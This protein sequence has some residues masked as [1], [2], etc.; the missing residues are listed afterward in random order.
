LTCQAEIN[1]KFHFKC[2]IRKKCN[3]VKQHFFFQETEQAEAMVW[4]TPDQSCRSE[5]PQAHPWA[6]V[7]G[8]CPGWSTENSLFQY[9]HAGGGRVFVFLQHAMS[10]N[11]TREARAAP[12]KIPAV[13]ELG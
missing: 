12:E 9:V 11:H 5:V 1:Q 10:R 6:V 13:Q 2:L 7:G 8:H 3:N 4:Q